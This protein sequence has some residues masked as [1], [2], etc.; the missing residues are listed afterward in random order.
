MENISYVHSPETEPRRYTTIVGAFKE[1][2]TKFPG[3]E[4]LIHKRS[5]G[6]RSALTYQEVYERAEILGKYLVSIGV[7]PGDKIV[8]IGP[9][10]LNWAVS[11]VGIL[12][13]GAVTVNATLGTQTGEDLRQIVVKAKCKGIIFDDNLP[14]NLLEKLVSNYITDK[15]CEFTICMSTT[16]LANVKTVDDII[17]KEAVAELPIVYPD[18]PAA[19][20]TT[21][22]STGKPK[23]VLH[24]HNSVSSV[25][26]DTMLHVSGHHRI[27]KIFNDRPFAWLG[28]S[29]L[30]IS[31]NIAITRL[32]ID[33]AKSS[34][35]LKL[36][37]IIE[38]EKCIGAG[39]IPTDLAEIMSKIFGSVSKYQLETVYTGGMIVDPKFSGM[40]GSLTKRLLIG[41]GSTEVMIFYT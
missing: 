17:A 19:M 6:D 1:A 22:G 18:D 2:A 41:Y 16:S 9:N 25:P 3:T 38:D 26:F 21:S 35:P 32:F 24:S 4:Y 31:Q 40:I 28:G 14:N 20:F 15:I 36:W 39:L 37:K 23:I 29:P 5:N 33:T 12:L 8:I 34:D 13:A 10:S 7:K 30:L 11:A 27:V